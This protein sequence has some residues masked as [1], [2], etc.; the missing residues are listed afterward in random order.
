MSQDDKPAYEPPKLI[1]L[2]SVHA[3]T[4][5]PHKGHG[6]AD[7]FSFGGHHITNASN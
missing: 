3:I 1:E 4:L 2:G 6:H 5:T 7:G